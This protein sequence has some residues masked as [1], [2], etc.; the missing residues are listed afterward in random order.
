MTEET[1]KRGAD[2]LSLDGVRVIDLAVG[3]LAA[4]G[5]LLA[6]LGADVIRVEPPEGAVDR[7]EGLL[8]GGVSLGFAA[9][10][11][12]KRAV[13]LDFGTAEGRDN[14]AALV[15]TADILIENTRPGS[16]E[17]AL[18]DVPGIHARHPALVILSATD[19]GQEGSYRSWQATGPVLHALSSQ[20]AR[21][22][23]PGRAP[24]LPPGDLP[25]ECAVPQAAFVV[26]AAYLNRLKTGYGDHLDFSVLDGVSQ[27]LDP[28]YGI[29]GSGTGGITGAML[30]RGRPEA[31]HQYPIF[32]C[33]DGYVRI[34]ILAARQWRGMF[35]WMGQ[36]EEFSDPSFN[37]MPVRYA[38]P[39]L[40]PA[41]A[42]LFADKTRAELEA[43]GQHYGV[44]TAGV[45]SLEEALAT[46]QVKARKVF[47][48]MDIAPGIS[49]PF[50]DG[51]MEIDGHRAGIRGP[52]PVLASYQP[53]DFAVAAKPHDPA[54]PSSPPQR[55]YPLAGLRVLCFGV[56]VVGAE[57]SR[58]LADLGAEVIKIENSDFPDGSR[59]V[60]Q[61][62][63]A[64]M[65]SSYAAGHRNKSSLGL[66][67]RTPEG[68]ALLHEL[69]GQA[70][71]IFSN[72]KPGTLESLGLDYDSLSAINPRLIMVDSSAFGP[73]G[74]WSRRMGYGPLVRA[75]TGFTAQWCYP[76]EP[77]SFSDALTVYPDHVAA[78][79]GVIGTLALLI[80]RQ[81]TGCGGTV[82][83]AQSEVMLSHMAVKIA[84]T[85]LVHEG[86]PL[87]GGP[88]FDAP[89]GVFACAGD[90]E[91]CVVTSRGD[92]DWQ[93]L[94]GVIGRPDLAAD[95]TLATAAGR[96]AQRSRIDQAVG[97]WLETRNPQE[98]MTLLQSA[99]VPA[100]EMLRVVDLPEFGYFKERGFFCK[101]THPL[102]PEPFYLENAPVRSE[103]LPDPQQNP[104]PLMGEQTVEV[105]RDLLGL[106]P[107]EITQLIEKKI[108]E[109][110]EAVS[111]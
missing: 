7:R 86:K 93:A 59:Q 67:L 76:G 23:I 29:F 6:E 46:D 5:R 31:R 3:P 108:L 88:E 49:A 10:N 83:V 101:V 80:R 63:N 111:R 50:P 106:S 16:A 104:A 61:N 70:D 73:T 110:S 72:F 35:E 64:L 48:P 38:S 2:A 54:P 18:L 82:S 95:Q 28:G 65:L 58:L 89:W 99:G 94:C 8:V 78:R 34:C 42:R 68:K 9:A 45:L 96:D 12:G 103:L 57:Q 26:L 21:S 52:V 25:Y 87:G 77:D 22:G 1:T 56:I 79:I 15:G 43:A 4:I 100:G 97:A 107:N 84:E 37:S 102:I 74:P 11:L 75:S 33:A 60:M 27:T 14:F 66:N 47:V 40:L 109:T 90:D 81:R 36:P 105:A 98:A 32:A 62:K 24:L 13:A 51:V 71:I 20:L 39:T 69:V 55:Q 17:A 85:V 91:W 44:P 19:F 30:P 92:A 41:I 53:Q